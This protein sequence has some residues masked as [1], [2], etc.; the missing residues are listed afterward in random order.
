[1]DDDEH[2]TKFV[3]FVC[4]VNTIYIYMF[5]EVYVREV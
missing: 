4:N 3:R 1:M 5:Y 2:E